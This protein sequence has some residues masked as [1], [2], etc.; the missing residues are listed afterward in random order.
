MQTSAT[1]LE[2]RQSWE[3]S[4]AGCKQEGGV[5][6]G[7]GDRFSTWFLGQR[8]EGRGTCHAAVEGACRYIS[9]I[10]FLY[11]SLGRWN[12]NLGLGLV[13]NKSVTCAC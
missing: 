13:D 11:L 6:D 12:N 4:P 9:L 2:N 3:G 8:G 1:V 10:R 5:R 7:Q